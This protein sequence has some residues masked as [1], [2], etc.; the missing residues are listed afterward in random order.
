MRALIWIVLLF[1]LAVGFSLAG[2]FDT[3]YAVLVYPPYRIELSLTLLVIVFLLLLVVGHV[4]FR[5]A[6]ATL[7]LPE[8]VRAYRNQQRVEAARG[9]LENATTALLEARY[10]RAEKLA[11][12]ALNLDPAPWQA[13]LIASQAAH[14]VRAYTRRDDYLAQAERLAP[15]QEMALRVTRARYLLDEQR[16]QEALLDIQRAMQLDPKHGGLQKLELRAQQQ[17]KN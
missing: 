13:A 3:G 4:F 7:R 15:A 14:E 6:S 2:K 12:E 5:L 10:E 16:A 1:A 9:A 11:R 17:L 8:T